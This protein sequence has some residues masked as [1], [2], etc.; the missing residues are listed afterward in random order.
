MP[1]ILS[2]ATSN[3]YIIETLAARVLSFV[4]QKLTKN[5]SPQF[6]GLTITDGPLV[7]NG[8]LQI[9]GKINEI[10]SD[11]S[12]IQDTSLILGVGNTLP[13]GQGQYAIHRGD[14]IPD[15]FLQYTAIDSQWS[16]YDGLTTGSVAHFMNLTDSK[17]TNF[18]HFPLF[19]DATTGSLVPSSTFV[20]PT[21]HQKSVTFPSGFATS[22][23]LG[24]DTKLQWLN[25]SQSYLGLNSIDNSI[26][27]IHNTSQ[28][29]LQDGCD[30][31]LGLSSAITLNPSVNGLGNNITLSSQVASL[32]SSAQTGGVDLVIDTG[33]AST[34][35]TLLIASTLD[36]PNRS[37]VTIQGGQYINRGLTFG[38]ADTLGVNAPRLYTLQCPTIN[39]MQYFGKEFVISPASSSLN[40]IVSSEVNFTGTSP[41]LRLSTTLN[42]TCANFQID[43]SLTTSQTTILRL[44]A[45]ARPSGNVAP[46]GLIFDAASSQFNGN[47]GVSGNFSVNGTF[48]Q[49]NGIASPSLTTTNLFNTN[50]VYLRMVAVSTPS[51]GWCQIIMTA[52]LTPNQS[53]TNSLPFGFDFSL[54][55]RMMNFQY[56][57]DIFITS[58]A[59]AYDPNTMAGKDAEVTAI[60]L[61]G[62]TVMRV[63]VEADENLAHTVQLCIL[64]QTI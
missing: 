8:D 48:S 49:A 63:T 22:L 36:S 37:S 60:P 34:G 41:A 28:L 29:S 35:G 32:P 23:L 2:K 54:P 5:S 19:L 62:S 57:G 31:A 61:L 39:T 59:V 14:T 45:L 12:K 51:T 3:P 40:P 20:V 50:A 7:L 17:T 33:A 25:S 47:A 24:I 10:N 64:Y 16:L 4:D 52:E 58:K 56:I 9:L 13:F 55:N 27:E 1:A 43:P 38:P 6:K 15:V 46:L 21:I 30:L 26:L 53:I 42:N 18:N 11:I 44:N